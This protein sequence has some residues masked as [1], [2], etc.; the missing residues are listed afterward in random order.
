MTHNRRI[1]AYLAAY[2]FNLSTILPGWSGFRGPLVENQAFFLL[3]GL[4]VLQVVEPFSTR[5]SKLYTHGF[6]A[7]HTILTGIFTASTTSIC[8]D[9]SGRGVSL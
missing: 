3:P 7:V 8:Q 5:Q 4:L 1:V 2:Y 6:M 9:M